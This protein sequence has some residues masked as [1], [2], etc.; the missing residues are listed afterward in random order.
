MVNTI[1]WQNIF[2]LRH[3]DHQ[4]H[5]KQIQYQCQ[6]YTKKIILENRIIETKMKKKNE[7]WKSKK[8]L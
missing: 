7:I 3:Q 1:K 8:K 6:V 2:Q 5:R 4:N